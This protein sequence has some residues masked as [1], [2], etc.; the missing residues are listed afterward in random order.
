MMAE[1]TGLAE[2]SPAKLE[3][4]AVEARSRTLGL[5]SDLSDE[6]FLQV[7]LLRIINPFLWEIGHVAY[8]QEYWVLRHANGEPPMLPDSDAWYDSAQVPHDTRW[9]LP[10]PAR[11]ATIGYLE[12]V[13]DKVLDRIANS[14]L[15]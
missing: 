13:R 5:V 8:F 2:F 4:W 15:S 11:S 10:L 12:A 9:N 14:S 7:P 6:Q 3:A 1:M